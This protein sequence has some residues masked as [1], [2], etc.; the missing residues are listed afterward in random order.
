MPMAEL[1]RSGFVHHDDTVRST[2]RDRGRGP[3]RRQ[4]AG[5]N[6]VGSKVVLSMAFRLM[7]CLLP[8][9]P[10][11][12]L[13]RFQLLGG[14]VVPPSRRRRGDVTQLWSVGM[15][16]RRPRGIRAI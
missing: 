16:F 10:M 14:E 4:G 3:G 9:L 11:D 12:S 1:K 6:V 5:G 2:G 15:G 8:S 7:P 13:T